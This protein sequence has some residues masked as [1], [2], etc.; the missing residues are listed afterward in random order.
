[1]AAVM[2]EKYSVN[3]KV[4]SMVLRTAKSLKNWFPLSIWCSLA[5]ACVF[6]TPGCQRGEAHFEPRELEGTVDTSLPKPLQAKQE[7]LARWLRGMQQGI[8]EIAGLRLM[9]PGV[10]MKES[11]DQF[12][13]QHKRLVRWE[14]NG[15]PVGVEVPVIL[16][17]DDVESGV[18]DERTLHREERVYA[19]NNTGNR[20]TIA[21]VKK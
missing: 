20:W 19:A 1:M 17:F 7:V 15:K 21:R 18:Y 5:L 10:D 13:N 9:V 3:S 2:V 8:G 16:Y 12:Y 6:T 14:F 4:N 11:F